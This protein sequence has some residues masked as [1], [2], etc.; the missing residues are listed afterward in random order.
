MKRFACVWLAL[1]VVCAPAVAA[2][3][4]DLLM[5]TARQM[6]APQPGSDTDSTVARGLKEAL[7]VGA[8]QVVA[9]VGRDDGYLANEAIRIGL[10]G[11]VRKAE[12]LLRSAGAGQLIDEFV[13]RMNRAAEQAAPAS[14]DIFVQAVTAMSFDDAARILNGPDDAATLYLR[15]TTAEKLAAVYRPIVTEAMS[16]EGVQAWYLKIEDQIRELPFMRLGEFDL[17]GYVTD[18]ALDGMFLM[19]ARE[20]QRIRSDPAAR[21]TDLLKQVFGTD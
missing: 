11:P 21:A 2:A 5:D 14:L 12:E 6:T 7:R 8:T 19:L 17:V 4:L 20:E 10:P 15:D 13:V 1:A 18:R 9:L 16:R 3:G